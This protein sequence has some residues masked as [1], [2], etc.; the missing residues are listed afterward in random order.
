MFRHFAFLTALF[1]AI[2]GFA[3]Q[4]QAYP[5]MIRHEYTACA[6]CHT[7]PSGAGLLTAYGRAQSSILLSSHYRHTTDE[8]PGSGKDFLFGL[9]P[10][11]DW[12]LLQGWLRNG[13]LWNN[14]NEHVVDSRFL[15]MRADLG[16]HVNVGALRASAT[17]GYNS[18][19][20]ATLSERAWVT[21]A[22]S[23]GNLV[24]REHWVGVA[25]AED[26][27]LA[28][29]GRI[30]LP[31]GL[32]N[33]EHTAWVRS[34]TRTDIN[35]SQQHGVA[36]AYTGETWRGELMG[37][38]GNF[39]VHPDAYRERGYAAF[40]EFSVAPR[41]AVGASSFVTH[42]TADILTQTNTTRQAHGVFARAAP[43]RA[44]VLLGE[45]DALLVSS[46]GAPGRNGYAGFLQL[47]T[48]PIQGVH[49]MVT[50]EILN[51]GGPTE[52]TNLGLWLSAAWF[53]LPHLDVRADAI[54]RTYVGAPA[55]LTYLLQ[56][57][58]YL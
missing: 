38:A 30:S 56:L 51:R 16:A 18:R 33:I 9:G 27:L 54:R 21:G 52:H 14:V 44:L 3:A 17:T 36:V 32:R 11:P 42:A 5:W 13:Y 12:L 8:E 29:A 25:L 35:Q 6:T 26:S 39:Q 28:R 1:W 47:D 48:E 10:L 23:N 40:V 7:D 22:S 53:A 19:Q 15:Q 58:A 49:G 34:E 57:Q 50:S 45:F 43:L 20:S 46:P 37:I 41:Y 24:S 4:A 31:F 55:T 2:V